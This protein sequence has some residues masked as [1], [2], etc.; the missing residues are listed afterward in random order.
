MSWSKKNNCETYGNIRI[1]H[2]FVARIYKS[3]PRVTA[4]HHEA[5]PSDAK[6]C[7]EGEICL[8]CQILFLVYILGVKA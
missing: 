2:E 4:W 6:Q 8:S 7:S 5:L 1:Y 3:L